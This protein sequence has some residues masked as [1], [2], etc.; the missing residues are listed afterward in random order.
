M[1][2]K[3]RTVHLYKMFSTDDTDTCKYNA[4]TVR[5]LSYERRTLFDEMVPW[6]IHHFFK[7]RRLLSSKNCSLTINTIQLYRDLCLF[8]LGL[9]NAE[10]WTNEQLKEKDIDTYLQK[11]KNVIN[12]ANT[13]ECVFYFNSYRL[14]Q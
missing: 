12:Y 6:N 14:N 4:C 7:K 10:Y 11:L 1:L 2:K 9:F 13:E 8:L 3:A 5:S